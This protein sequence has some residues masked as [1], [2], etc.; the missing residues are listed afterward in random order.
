MKEV[1]NLFADK[2]SDPEHKEV[3]V[4]KG[5]ES[6]LPLIELPFAQ[7][8]VMHLI[9]EEKSRFSTGNCFFGLRI[10][11][12]IISLP[13]KIGYTNIHNQNF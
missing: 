6:K 1:L 10:E 9:K 11:H 4:F 2:L 7:K 8:L 13:L 5:N 3:N 12:K